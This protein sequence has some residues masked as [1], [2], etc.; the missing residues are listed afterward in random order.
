MCGGGGVFTNISFSEV[1]VTFL[2]CHLLFK[3]NN[4]QLNMEHK[5]DLGFLRGVSIFRHDVNVGM[6]FP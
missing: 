4:G 5:A 1:D 2:E 3:E 6:K